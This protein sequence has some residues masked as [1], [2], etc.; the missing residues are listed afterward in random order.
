MTL[1]VLNGDSLKERFPELP[2]EIITMRECLMEGPVSETD[3][4]AFFAARKEF[5]AEFDD[6]ENSYDLTVSELMRMKEPDFT[7]IYL[8]FEED[9]FCQVNMWFLID[10]CRIFG[11]TAR[12]W[13]VKTAD[14]RPYSFAAHSNAELIIQFDLKMRINHLPEWYGLWNSYRSDDLEGFKKH[15]LRLSSEY[16][17]V[18]RAAEA[19]IARNPENPMAGRPIQVLKD[20]ISGLDNPAF[21][22][23]FMEFCKREPIYGY[24][25]LQIK[26]MYDSL[27]D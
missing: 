17:Y 10:L 13:H 16:P 21:G 25:D 1:H 24:G 12:L 8:W 26:V 18:L 23:V 27:V 9:L 2:G 7:D 15:A 11:A 4:Q 5:L 14:D 3:P 22:P 6:E 20:I 19:H